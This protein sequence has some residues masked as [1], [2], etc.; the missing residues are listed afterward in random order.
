MGIE[1]KKEELTAEVLMQIKTAGIVD[2][3]VINIDK[4]HSGHVAIWGSH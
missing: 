4:Y 1:K 2:V 3:K